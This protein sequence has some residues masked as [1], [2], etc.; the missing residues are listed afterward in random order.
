VRVNELMKDRVKEWAY[1]RVGMQ[2][3]VWEIKADN[4]V[5]Q[6][7]GPYQTKRDQILKYHHIP[8]QSETTRK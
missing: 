8:D 1:M 3:P 5:P 4:N 2:K 7:I 6:P